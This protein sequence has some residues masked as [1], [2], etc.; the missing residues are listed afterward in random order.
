MADKTLPRLTRLGDTVEVTRT[1]SQADFDRFAALSGDDNPIHVDAA[2]A[3]ASHF[4]RTVSH[5]MLLYA[6][7]AALLRR[8][9]LTGGQV[10]Q[11][12]MFPNPAFAGEPVRFVATVTAVEG[13]AVVLEQR[14]TRG[15][16]GAVVCQGSAR[17][18][19]STPPMPRAGEV[20]R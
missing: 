7:F 15:S 6:V 9:G 14:A 4:G 13:D 20:A 16:D 8:S 1:F 10:G 11:D 18:R 2:Y 19:V 17:C 12:L 5:G 3:A